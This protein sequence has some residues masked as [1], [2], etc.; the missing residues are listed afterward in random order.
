MTY[1]KEKSTD[2]VASSVNFKSFSEN[3]TLYSKHE[4]YKHFNYKV[5]FFRK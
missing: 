1:T 2:I 3:F 4:W 5:L